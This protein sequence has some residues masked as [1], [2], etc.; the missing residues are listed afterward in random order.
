MDVALDI[1]GRR[2]SPPQPSEGSINFLSGRR[3]NNCVLSEYK[4][5]LLPRM[6]RW[7]EPVGVADDDPH[8]VPCLALTCLKKAS[9]LV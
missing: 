6:L 9:L 4:C 7:D 5:D 3:M 1:A 2:T 8:P